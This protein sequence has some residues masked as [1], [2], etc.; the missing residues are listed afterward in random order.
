MGDSTCSP[1]LRHEY[2]LSDA[3]SRGRH[4]WRP[5]LV[6]DTPDNPW[7]SPQAISPEDGKPDVVVIPYVGSHMMVHP[8][9]GDGTFGPPNDV[10]LPRARASVLIQG[11]QLGFTPGLDHGERELRV[12]V[13]GGA[14]W[15][16]TDYFVG[17]TTWGLATGDLDHDGGVG[18]GRWKRLSGVGLHISRERRRPRSHGRAVLRVLEPR[19]L[20]SRSATS[21]R[22]VGLIS[23]LPT[24]SYGVTV[25]LGVGGGR[26]GVVDTVATS[27]TPRAWHRRTWTVTAG[28]IF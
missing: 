7:R 14:E 28:W 10:A 22:T 17:V 18:S 11:R 25:F 21:T 12:R 16:R 13:A 4:L 23:R 26:F 24:R 2:V 20:R 9:N 6:L 19:P 5:D 27:A 8:G 1:R 15:P 3:R